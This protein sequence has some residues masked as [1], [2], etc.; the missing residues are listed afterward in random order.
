MV[1]IPIGI[2]PFRA[3]FS[4]C[5]V[6]LYRTANFN[7]GAEFNRPC[8]ILANHYIYMICQ[9][10]QACR[11]FNRAYSYPGEDAGANACYRGFSFCIKGC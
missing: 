7:A 8:V 9:G 6:F 10:Q 4:S 5:I 1:F 3:L 2:F 11:W